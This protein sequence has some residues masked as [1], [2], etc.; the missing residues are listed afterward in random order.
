MPDSAFELDRL[1]VDCFFGMLGLRDSL[2]PQMPT[3]GDKLGPYEI[4]S[5][6]G[7]GGMGEVFRAR[8]TRLNRD[9]AI[10]ASVEQFTGRFE[11]EARAIAALNH[12][13]I[14]HLYDVGPN[15]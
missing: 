2:P 1:A 9:V 13:T 8:D 4:L 14:C 6:I 5:F 15:Y 11:R 7:K 3:T 12:P 10:K